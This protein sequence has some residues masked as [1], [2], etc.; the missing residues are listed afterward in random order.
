MDKLDWFGILI[1]SSIGL[2]QSLGVIFRRIR[3]KK[4]IAGYL[5]TV[6]KPP[7]VLDAHWIGEPIEPEE[8]ED[9]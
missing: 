4:R 7:K 6:S 3:P 8:E 9:E 1:I 5:G 2:T